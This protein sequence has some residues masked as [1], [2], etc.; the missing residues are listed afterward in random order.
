MKIYILV[1]E[2]RLC[3]MGLRNFLRGD[4]LHQKITENVAT[5]SARTIAYRLVGLQAAVVVIVALC[6]SMEGIFGILSALLGGGAC[7]LPSF[8]FAKR[9][10]ATTSARATKKIIRT[11]YLGEMVKLVFTAVLVVLIILF[12]HVAIAPFITG[13]VGAQLG[14]WLAPMLTKIGGIHIDTVEER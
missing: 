10:F 4:F 13:F 8:Y 5:R 6:W 7:V 9:F 2:I 14:F 12:I 11:F 3:R 1:A